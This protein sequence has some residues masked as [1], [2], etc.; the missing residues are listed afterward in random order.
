MASNTITIYFDEC[1]PTPSNGYRISYRPI[2]SAIP[3]RVWPVNFMSTPAEFIDNNDPIGTS[4]EGFIQ[5][6]CGGGKYGVSLPWTAIN[7]VAP[8]ESGSASGSAS[9]PPAVPCR[10]IVMT[11]TVGTPSAHYIDCAGNTQDTLINTMTSICTNGHGFTISGGGVTVNSFT[12]GDCGGVCSEGC[13]QYQAIA[14]DPFG[15]EGFTWV[16]CQGGV[17]VAT[18]EWGVPFLFCTCDA[19]PQYSTDNVTVSRVGDCP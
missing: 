17:G 19:N 10:T 8:S 6:D 5:G 4:Y 9:E 7:E 2:G 12:D 3:Y 18:V 15:V 16:D 14:E 1:E 13:G 11:K